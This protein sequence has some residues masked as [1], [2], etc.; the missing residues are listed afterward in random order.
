MSKILG[1][2][3]IGASVAGS[4]GGQA[5][6]PSIA[7]SPDFTLAAIG[8]S[9]MESAKESAAHFGAPLAF[10]DPD[11]LARDPSV[12]V[13]AVCVRV[14]EH[15]RLVMAALNAGKHFY[16]EWPLAR[17]TAE[18]ERLV[19]AAKTAGVVHLAGMQARAVPAIV[20]L[21]QLIEAGEIGTILS[22]S[23]TLAGHWSPVFPASMEYLQ[24]LESGGNYFTIAG[25]H[26]LDAFRHVLGPVAELAATTMIRVP[27]VTL[28]D[29][30]RTTTRTAPDHFAFSGTLASGAF[31]SFEVRG[32][33]TGGSGLRFEVNGDKGSLLITASGANPMIQMSDLTL[34]RVAE[35]GA[36]TPI[37]PPAD[38]LW[39][40]ASV[41]PHA[42]GV[43][44][45]YAR[46]GEAIRGGR[47]VL[48]D[49]AAALDNHRL[50]DAIRRSADEG[51]K[52]AII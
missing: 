10:D 27:D 43:A 35:D 15:E 19:A 7:A 23:L 31:A 17:D 14:P 29:A 50:L 33:P 6:I 48:S 40:D 25:G 51:Q 16:C 9:R 20:H 52:I 34:A 38:C 1:V 24:K 37:D 26:A 41:G 44:Q 12:D 18:A 21:K 4:W 47:P 5:H 22:A 30:A 39:A 46:L 32:S 2:G 3:V 11:A 36:L 45:S 13:V 8:T 28:F 49:F 42:I